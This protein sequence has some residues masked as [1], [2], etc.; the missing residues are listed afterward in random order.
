[1]TNEPPF[2]SDYDTADEVRRYAL[3]ER[4][5]H[6]P[7]QQG[8]VGFPGRC[9]HCHFTRHPCSVYE[10]ATIVLALIDR[11]APVEDST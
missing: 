8:D 3:E 4:R 5:I 7:E 11:E 2:I 9:A 1:V 10:L 6:D